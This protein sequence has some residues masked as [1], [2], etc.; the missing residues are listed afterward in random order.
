MNRRFDTRWAAWRLGYPNKVYALC[1]QT[2]RYF[3]KTG[4]SLLLHSLSVIIS[5]RQSIGSSITGAWVRLKK[6]I[7]RIVKVTAAFAPCYQAP[8]TDGME[9][10][11]DIFLTTILWGRYWLSNQTKFYA[12]M[13]VC[14][15]FSI[16]SATGFIRFAFRL[17]YRAIHQ[18]KSLGYLTHCL[19]GINSRIMRFSKSCDKLVSKIHSQ[20]SKWTRWPESWKNWEIIQGNF[21]GP[22]FN[23]ALGFDCRLFLFLVLLVRS[24][25]HNVCWRRIC[26]RCIAKS[27]HS[28]ECFR[29]RLP[30]MK[31]TSLLRS[32]KPF[33]SGRKHLRIMHANSIHN[34]NEI[35]R[36]VWCTPRIKYSQDQTVFFWVS[37]EEARSITK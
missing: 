7:S 16:T 10:L 4:K 14:C 18:T 28:W 34:M 22:F 9:I 12:W 35:K 21:C 6:I 30:I 24:V 3:F 11:D 36:S 25:F 17:S 37:D 32:D 2:E 26:Y 27:S 20:T 5:Q 23:W 8:N 29:N 13:A 1:L 31:P 33:I 19:P 15:N